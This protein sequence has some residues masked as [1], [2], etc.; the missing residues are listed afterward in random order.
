MNRAIWTAMS[1]DDLALA[2]KDNRTAADILLRRFEPGAD[3]RERRQ[4]AAFVTRRYGYRWLSSDDGMAIVAMRTWESLDKWEP[5]TASFLT[6][7]QGC[8]WP[9]LNH[10][11]RAEKL[12]ASRTVPLNAPVSKVDS[13]GY[14]YDAPGH[15]TA[16]SEETMARWRELITAE[17][18][19]DDQAPVK[20]QIEAMRY[21]LVLGLR[22]ERPVE[23]AARMYMTA[24]AVLVNGMEVGEFAGSLA[25][26]G[27][28]A[29]DAV[30]RFAA[31]LGDVRRETASR[32]LASARVAMA[33]KASQRGYE[34]RLMRA[35]LL[36]T[37]DALWDRL[38]A[39]AGLAG[40]IV[41]GLG[42]RAA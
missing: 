3:T 13:E 5:K 10:F 23:L 36:V 6:F 17:R 41:E 38:R 21:I 1:T 15:A 37:D 4:L 29:D 27:L 32:W 24:R 25:A 35:A 30:G 12:H 16:D 42:E 34:E 18:V 26:R 7:L 8:V 19:E 33:K 20:Q 9:N 40:V 31:Y 39:D 22:D 2:A 28:M 11:I 14:R